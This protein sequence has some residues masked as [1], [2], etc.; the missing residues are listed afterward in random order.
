[1]NYLYNIFTKGNYPFFFEFLYWIVLPRPIL[2][3]L[4]V[5]VEDYLSIFETFIERTCRGKRY[6]DKEEECRLPTKKQF[7]EI[8]VT[9]EGLN[10]SSKQVDEK[11]KAYDEERFRVL[12]ET[13]TKLREVQLYYPIRICQS[14]IRAYRLVP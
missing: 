11:L 14:L 8:K 13:F 12:G 9:I 2:A 5:Y 1:M 10:G 6:Y 3:N 4:L 7:A